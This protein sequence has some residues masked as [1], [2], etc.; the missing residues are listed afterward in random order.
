MPVRGTK[1]VRRNLKT[2]VDIIQRA[3]LPIA[4]RKAV[5]ALGARADQYVPIDTSALINSRFTRV[6]TFGSSVQ[7][8]VGYT[9]AYA[10]ALHSPESGGRLD[11]WKPQPPGTPGKPNGGFNPKAE[12]GWLDI[13][14]DEAMPVIDRIF[15]KELKL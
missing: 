9:Q 1:N 6:Q 15:I 5:F 2:Q 14:A 4:M 7:G 11:G 10:A 12:Q 13:G 3:K 8:V